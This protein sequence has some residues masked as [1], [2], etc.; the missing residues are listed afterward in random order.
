MLINGNL[1]GHCGLYTRLKQMRAR[2]G[3]SADRNERKEK[4]ETSNV[5]WSPYIIHLLY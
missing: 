1:F 4:L 3:E 2:K 5:V